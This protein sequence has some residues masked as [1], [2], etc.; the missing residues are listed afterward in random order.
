MEC[1]KQGEDIHVIPAFYKIDPSQVRK[2]SGSYHAAFAKHEKDRKVSEEKMQK[3][4]NALYEATNLSGFHSNAYRCIWTESD[5]IEE[6]AR[7]VL[8]KLNHKNYPN[9]FRG[10]FISDENC[11]NI[12]SLLKIESE[13]VRVIGIW[14]IGGIGK[15]TLAAA[16]FHKVSSH[17][18]DTCFSENMAEETKRHG[19]NYV[20]NKLLS[21]LLK[22]DLHIDT[23][24]VIPYIVKRRLMNKKVLVVTDDVNTSEVL[25]K[26][27]GVGRDCLG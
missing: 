22:K 20:Y 6:I 17:Y 16:I 27:V 26:L 9:D 19:L 13:E 12:E 15:T 4:K 5:M 18:E 24:K 3:W 23:P 11:S 25:D 10:H 2:Q 21:K 7:V 14:G 8:Q 1:K